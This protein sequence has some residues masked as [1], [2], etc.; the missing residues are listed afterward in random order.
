M[1]CIVIGSLKNNLTVTTHQMGFSSLD[2]PDLFCYHPG[3]SVLDM[4]LGILERKEAGAGEGKEVES[5][6]EEKNRVKIITPVCSQSHSHAAQQ[7]C[8]GGRRS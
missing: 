2:L 7:G 8:G 5:D 4:I 3:V 6:Q 1:I